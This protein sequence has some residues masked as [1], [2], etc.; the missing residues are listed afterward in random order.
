MTTK[1]LSFIQEYTEAFLWAESK[2][3]S[4]LSSLEK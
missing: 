3:A 2:W 4:E 1:K